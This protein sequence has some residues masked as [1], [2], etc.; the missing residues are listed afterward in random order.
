MW[1]FVSVWS[2]FEKILVFF[3]FNGNLVAYRVE[4]VTSLWRNF[5]ADIFL[6]NQVIYEFFI[7]IFASFYHHVQ[8]P[9]YWYVQFA[10]GCNRQCY[11][12]FLSRRSR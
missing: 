5:R 6:D 4:R 7:L 12:A 10:T 3:F 11:A 2:A 1:T 8:E 9:T